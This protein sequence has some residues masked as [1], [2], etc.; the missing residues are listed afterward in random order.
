M[1]PTPTIPKRHTTPRRAC[2]AAALA[3][4]AGLPI[5]AARAQDDTLT[6]APP[7][8]PQPEGPYDGRYVASVTLLLA[9]P[10]TADFLPA[11]PATDQ[12]VRNQIRTG[13]GSREYNQSIAASDIARLNRL[14]R[15]SSVEHVIAPRPDGSVDITFRLVR[16]P[17]IADVQVTG[18]RR[19]RS[20]TIAKEVEFLAG[21]PVDQFELDRAARAIEDLYREKGFHLAGVRVNLDELQ[22]TGVVLFEVREGLRTRITDV[23]FEGNT[24]FRTEILT[25]EIDTRQA[26]IF[27]TGP[28]DDDTLR[29]DER[30]LA[31]FYKERGYLD[32]RVGSTVT[33]SPDSRE[34]IVTFFVEEGPLYTLRTVVAHHIDADTSP[35][36]SEEQ[37]VGLIDMKPG[38]TY[39]HL[40]VENAVELV[41]S[42][43]GQ[44][45]YVDAYVQRQ[46][47]RDPAR[48]L[49]DLVLGIR[50]GERFRTGLVQVTGNHVTRHEEIR[51]LLPF[52]PDRPL[53]K[54]AVDRAAAIL[55]SSRLFDAQSQQPRTAILN[56]QTT[57][58]GSTT[59][60]QPEQPEAP[61]NTEARILPPL[62]GDATYRDVLVEVTETNTGSLGFGAAV[63][64]DAGVI[65]NIS[66]TQRNFD[67]TDTPDSL[68]DLFSGKS[69][70]GG[71]QTFTIQAQPGSETGSYSIS[72]S[73]NSINDSVIGGSASAFIRTRDYNEYDEERRGIGAAISR[74]FGDRWRGSID[75]RLQSVN[76]SAI[77]PTSPTDLFDSGGENLLTGLGFGLRRTTVPPQESFRP[78]QGTIF[79]INAEQ[80]GALGGDYDFTKLTAEHSVFLSLSEDYL[81]SNTVLRLNTRASYIPQGQGDTPVFERYYLGGKNMRG[82]DFRTVG[83]RGLRND[84]GQ[85]SDDPIGGTWLF[86]WG[87]ELQQPII[88]EDLALAFFVDTG[89]VGEDFSFDDYR[90]SIGAG[91]RLYIP[92]LSPAPLAFDF[93]FP[94]LKEDTDEERLFTFDID[95]P[96]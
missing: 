15:F 43:Y 86:F 92:Q 30:A 45:G 18:N 39:S 32:A 75:F 7:D 56:R 79:E 36:L 57:G 24:S 77:D 21:T 74:R 27:R 93:G 95:L 82:F 6:P 26:G 35:V 51:K 59:T 94:I 67:I 8:L 3:L 52:R 14:G 87:A 65:G 91:L 31:R 61:V 41:Q 29:A 48:P 89:T 73:D 83:P 9:E 20:E 69:F 71:G 85:P 47:I 63:N 28:L 16:Q 90:V 76:I 1:W 5:S 84:N 19:V 53:D 34:A 22:N 23:R 33:T 11:D 37:I 70:R 49:V 38:D 10:G 62:P 54:T 88:G 25:R 44:M 42:A 80:V 81:G 58:L 12:L 17:V 64:S 72:L 2:L 46:E 78:T 60:P 40:K 96:I 66:F 68:G 13:K 55:A 50:Q 4:L